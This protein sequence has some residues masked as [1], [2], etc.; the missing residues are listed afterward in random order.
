MLYHLPRHSDHH[1][2]PM[3]RYQALRHFEEAPQLPTGYAGMSAITLFPF[4]WRRMV[5]PVLVAHAGGDFS[6]INVQPSQREK[7]LARWGKKADR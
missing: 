6:K 7:L 1:A 5:D 3:R 4:I 2:F